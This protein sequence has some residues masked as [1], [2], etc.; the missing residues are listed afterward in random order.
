VRIYRQLVACYPHLSKIKP[1]NMVRKLLFLPIFLISVVSSAQLISIEKFLSDSSMFHGSASIC[2]IDASNGEVIADY[3]AGKSLSQAS[4]MKL[5][6]TSAS[7]ELLG[8]DYTFNT[9]LGYTGRIKKSTKTLKGN[10]IIKGGGDPALGSERFNEHYEHFIEKWVEEVSKLG[11]RRIKGRVVTDDSYYDYKPVPP[12]WSWEDIGNYYGA[13]VYGLSIYDNTLKIH[14]RTGDTGSIPLIIG[15]EPSGSGFEYL[16][17]LLASGS[18]DQGFVYSA[19]YSNNGWISGTIPVN[20]ED[21]AL[22][23]SINNPPLLAARILSEKLHSAGIKVKNGPS[24]IRALPQLKPHS[25]KVITRTISPPLSEIIEVLNHISFNLYAEHLI[26]ELGKVYKGEGSTRAGTEVVIE[27]L[28]SI[29][30]E[31]S[32]MFIEDGSGLSP[33]D[34][35][36]SRELA[37]LLLY[38]KNDSEHFQEFFNSLPEAGKE[39]TLKNVFKDPLFDSRLRAKSGTLTR[40]KSYAGYFTTISGKEMIFSIIVNNFTGPSSKIVSQIEEIIKE[41]ILT[42]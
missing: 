7:L 31:T 38:M 17:Y 34:A 39:G 25:I 42:R 6:T 13:G 20:T 22:P 28:D 41:V 9:I 15:M 12:N 30:I 3:S 24:S 19:P 21:F 32:G 5:I 8:P 2:I 1:D 14:L 33:Q 18:S 26:K 29:G 37:S 4:V 35:I 40:V 10:L 36:N 11:I 23:A 27:F 16:N